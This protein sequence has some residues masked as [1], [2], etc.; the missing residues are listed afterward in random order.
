MLDSFKTYFQSKAN[1]TDEQFLLISTTLQFK[2]EQTAPSVTDGVRLSHHRAYGSRTRRFAK[3]W[4]E[5]NGGFPHRPIAFLLESQQGNCR[6][7][8]RTLG[9]APASFSCPTPSIGV[10]FINSQSHQVFPFTFGFSSCVFINFFG[11][12]VFRFATNLPIRPNAIAQA[13]AQ[14]TID[15]S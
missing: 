7:Q 13:I 15:F 1:L 8:N 14:P 3:R 2:I 9:N 5:F 6:S 10:V 12:R 4:V 11:I